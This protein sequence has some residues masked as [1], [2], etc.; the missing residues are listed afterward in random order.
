MLPEEL[1]KNNNVVRFFIDGKQIGEG[2]ASV[3]DDAVT[4]PIPYRI[5]TGK[6]EGTVTLSEPFYTNPEMFMNAPVDVV[7]THLGRFT[8]R[9]RSKKK[10]IQK[11]WYKKNVLTQTVYKNCTIKEVL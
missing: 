1:W 8:K 10:R 2:I 5:G 3:F 9:P 6:L 4:T 7:V 11:K